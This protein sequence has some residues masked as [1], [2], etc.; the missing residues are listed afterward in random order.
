MTIQFDCLYSVF[1]ELSN[2]IVH[3]QFV[4]KRNR[5]WPDFNEGN[6][7][8]TE[9]FLSSAGGGSHFVETESI[10]SSAGGGSHFVETENV[11]SPA[12][13][14]SQFVEI[15]LYLEKRQTRQQLKWKTYCRILRASYQASSSMQ[16]YP[17][18]FLQNTCNRL[19][20]FKTHG[21]WHHVNEFY[22]MFCVTTPSGWLIT[23][24]DN[25]EL[26]RKRLLM[27]GWPIAGSKSAIAS[28]N[29]PV[30]WCRID[31]SPSS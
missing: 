19:P 25:A 21:W 1:D 13:G 28:P 4:S 17:T 23:C 24:N 20:L 16:E 2:V 7:A 11:F 10:L 30:S 8:K 29:D 12:S 31:Q 15:W 18:P 14:S 26:M 22:K 9:E 27:L 3:A 6:G 5:S